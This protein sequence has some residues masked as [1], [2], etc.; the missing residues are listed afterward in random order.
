MQITIRGAG[1]F[2]LSIAWTLR[3]AG[4]QV[5]VIDP[6]G[7]GAGASGGIVGALA[8]HVPEAWN[9]KKAFQ[10]DSLLMA[11]RFWAEVARAG[12]TSP[13]YARSGRLQPIE[14]DAALE[15]AHARAE[16]ARTLWRGEADWTVLRASD[17]GGWAPV[18]PSGWLIHDTLS[19]RLHPRRACAALA[20]ALAR[21][22]VEITPEGREGD[23]VIHATGAAGLA[24]IPGPSG[25]AGPPAGTGIKGQA[26]LLD[27]SVPAG[28]AQ[29]FAGGVHVIPHADGTVGIGSTTERDWSDPAATDGALDTVIAQ[30]RAAVPALRD[31]PVIGR[32]A[33]LRPRARS[34]AP[35]L[36]PWP[37][38]PGH[39][40]ANGGFKIG[41]GI[42]PG[43][44][45]AMT[46]LVLE[47]VDTIPA[48]FAPV[49]PR[50]G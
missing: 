8:P 26:A 42:A 13:G 11:E 32:W 16:G 27:A 12:G 47:G 2:G 34:R 46:R 35:L 17:A 21:N 33:G 43:V 15:R 50:E 7:P 36:G 25:P 20:A 30:A 49:P 44:A 48:G 14:D 29:I 19:A 6:G 45:L 39:F 31:A 23:C 24:R 22:G 4:A 37:G 41:F 1:I 9:D 5:S 28:A 38:R 40:I 3:M 18:S 10:L